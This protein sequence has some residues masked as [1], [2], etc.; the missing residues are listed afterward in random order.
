MAKPEKG[1]PST[2]WF[3][4]LPRVISRETVY[5]CSLLC[6]LHSE[7]VSKEV[8]QTICSARPMSFLDIPATVAWG[9]TRL[10]RAPDVVGRIGRPAHPGQRLAAV[11]V[12]AAA[13]GKTTRVPPVQQA[14]TVGIPAAG[15][16]RA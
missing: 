8:A 1:W 13:V 12:G 11:V 6:S 14:A 4:H 10:R 16:A 15:R 7:K 5:H 2:R 3:G 9:T